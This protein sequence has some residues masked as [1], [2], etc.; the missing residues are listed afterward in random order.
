MEP[1][2]F[3]AFF[4]GAPGGLDVETIRREWLALRPPFD[5]LERRPPVPVW[6]RRGL[7]ESG[8]QA[9][10]TLKGLLAQAS[11]LRPFCIYVHIPFCG[12]K[13]AFCDCY[14]F[15]LA[16][17]SQH[18][19]DQ[20]VDLLVQEVELWA[21]QGMLSRRP[22]STVH[23]GG[24]TPTF[25]GIAPFTR[26]VERSRA[27]F[28]T[29]S[30][31]EWAL[32]TTSFEFDPPMQAA[33]E[34]LGFTRLHLGVQSLEEPVRQ[35]IGRLEPAKVV[36]EKIAS[37]VHRGWI[38]S[39]DLI[40]GLP[41]QTLAGVYADLQR[42]IDSGVDGF[43]VYELQR[44]PRNRR[45]WRQAGLEQQG[46]LPAYFLFQAACGWLAAAGYRK[47]LF[48]HFA[49]H[50]DANLYFTFPERDEDCLAV[51]TIA[52]GVFGDYHYRHPEY[53][54]YTR[55]V[56]PDFPGLQGGM[57]KTELERRLK[58]LEIAVLSGR[59]QRPLFEEVLGLNRAAGLFSNWLE[60]ALIQPL[61]GL[62]SYELTAN[63]S[64][65]AG[66]MLADLVQSL[67]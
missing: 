30:A 18:H 21:R 1:K 60:L 22:V 36:L 24:G 27:A 3:D 53:V 35:A 20:Y 15:H 12:R 33:L 7:T 63:G 58:P 54:P 4:A 59:L 66:D 19:I 14:S 44:S 67:A 29:S 41:G 42:L 13:C 65:L 45:F 25:L 11:P 28:A 48:N 64:W 43:S 51:G 56:G 8:P 2:T 16:R 50:K 61:P 10:D 6:A 46:R 52:D 49:R 23:F 9:W 62:D 47:N 26:L 31:T 34:G 37:A 57:Q 55:S 32:E 5:P 40:V 17:Q 39:V 38:A